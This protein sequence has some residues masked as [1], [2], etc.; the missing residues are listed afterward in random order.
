MAGVG[1]RQVTVGTGRNRLGQE[2]WICSEY[3]VLVGA[4]E[5]AMIITRVFI[6]PKKKGWHLSQ[7]P[8]V[9]WTARLGFSLLPS[10]FSAVWT[11]DYR[12]GPILSWGIPL[13][14]WPLSVPD[15]G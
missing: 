15:G 4:Q 7:P 13:C 10:V 3:Q 8:L 11:S 14:G 5:L 1:E 6:K 2:G 9:T 12:L